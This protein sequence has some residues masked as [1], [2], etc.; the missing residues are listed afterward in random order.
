MTKIVS[1]LAPQIF[2]DFAGFL[3]LKRYY[4]L[5][6]DNLEMPVVYNKITMYVKFPE[7]Y[8]GWLL[9]DGDMWGFERFLQGYCC[10]H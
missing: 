4:F 1:F 6:S 2:T 3:L 9:V 7:K 8:L 10:H 5:I